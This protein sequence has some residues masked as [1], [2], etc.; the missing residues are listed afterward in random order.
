MK[1]KQEKINE[2]RKTAESQKAA[3]KAQRT[4]KSTS[5]AASTGGKKGKSV[6]PQSKTTKK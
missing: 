5:T 1:T 6:I 3:K 2:A 4:A